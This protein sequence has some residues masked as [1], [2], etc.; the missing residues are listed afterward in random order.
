[1]LEEL[2]QRLYPE[3]RAGQ[4]RALVLEMGIRALY[5]QVTGDAAAEA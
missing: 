1:M 3:R 2:R 4:A 5:R